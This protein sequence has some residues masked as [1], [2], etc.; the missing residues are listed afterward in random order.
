MGTAYIDWSVR[1]PGRE[2]YVRDLLLRLPGVRAV[3]HGSWTNV[4][5]AEEARRHYRR[6]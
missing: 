2:A 6:S 4:Q 5:A 1:D 3:V